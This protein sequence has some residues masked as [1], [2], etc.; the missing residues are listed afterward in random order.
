MISQFCSVLPSP[1]GSIY[2]NIVC[3]VFSACF[4]WLIDLAPLSSVILQGNESGGHGASPAGTFC[5]VPEVV[6]A[7]AAYAKERGAQPI[8]V[9]AAGGVTDGRQVRI[10]S[11]HLILIWSRFISNVT[12]QPEGILLTASTSTGCTPASTRRRSHH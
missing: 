4:L 7:M 9:L 8:P 1:K 3:T 10:P 2:L 5:F 12:G 11:F 6:D